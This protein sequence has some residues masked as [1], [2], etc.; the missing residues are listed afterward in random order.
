MNELYYEITALL[1]NYNCYKLQTKDTTKETWQY[2][3][4]TLIND[5]GKNG[6]GYLNLSFGKHRMKLSLSEMSPVMIRNMLHS[7]LSN[8][9]E[10]TFVLLSQ[11]FI[12]CILKDKNES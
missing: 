12:D 7:I 4:R 2:N 10:K 8:N 9:S 5:L 6:K 3:N 11:I 1:N